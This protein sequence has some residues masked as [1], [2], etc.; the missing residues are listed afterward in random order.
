MAI[1]NLVAH[2]GLMETCPE[3]TLIS[4]ESAILCGAAYIEFDVQCTADGQ[5]VLFHDTNLLRTTGI[6]G[7]LFEMSYEEL[8]NIRAHEPDRFSLAF[9][10]QH[11]PLLSDAVQLLQSCPRVTAF[12]E[13]KHD[14]LLQFGIEQIMP[15][16]LKTLEIIHAQCVVISYNADAISYMKNH[17]DIQCGW[18]VQQYDEASHQQARKLAP[19]YLIANH[20]KLPENAEPW[21]GNWH[22]MVYDITDPELA[23]HYASL[24]IPLIETRDICKMLEHPVLALNALELQNQGGSE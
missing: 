11:I 5:L 15:D 10:N 4:L 21:P 22:W 23:L 18:I 12:V 14:S 8:K 20:R 17:S 9:F 13:I 16:L 2:R 1:P 3:N 6:Q 7:K 24:N 19:D